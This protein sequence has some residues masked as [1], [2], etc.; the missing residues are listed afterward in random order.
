MHRFVNPIPEN[1]MYT[2][3]DPFQ[4]KSTVTDPAIS[5]NLAAYWE[6]EFFDEMARLKVREP[7][8][9]TRVT[10]Y[11][12]EIV[13]YVERIIQNG[14]AYEAEGSVYFDTLTFDGTDGHNYAKL[15]PWSKGNR[16]LLEGGEGD[17]FVLYLLSAPD[18]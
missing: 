16:E 18:S 17:F 1:E 4:L 15:E 8:I 5:R 14:Y 11:V 2:I 3:S 7:D 10:E 6:G 12:P 13:A 9:V